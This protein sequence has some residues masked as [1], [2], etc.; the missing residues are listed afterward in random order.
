MLNKPLHPHTATVLPLVRHHVP[1]DKVLKVLKANG[2][3]YGLY[4]LC[5]QL[6]AVEV[7][8][9]SVYAVDEDLFYNTPMLLEKQAC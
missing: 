7:W 5:K 6:H 2:I 9:H 8:E 1:H 3:P 4:R